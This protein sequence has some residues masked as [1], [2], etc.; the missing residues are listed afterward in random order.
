M[1]VSS[2]P[3]PFVAVDA[4]T[5]WAVLSIVPPGEFVEHAVEFGLSRPLLHDGVQVCVEQLVVFES[6]LTAPGS[7]LVQIAE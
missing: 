7:P 3:V 1:S 5:M 4:A 6:G 2:E